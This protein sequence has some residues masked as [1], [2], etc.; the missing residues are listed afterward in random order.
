MLH[1]GCSPRA[2]TPSTKVL[3]RKSSLLFFLPLAITTLL[4][5]QS[6]PAATSALTVVD[7]F[8]P[9]GTTVHRLDAVI[10]FFSEPV[11]GVDASDFLVNGVAATNLVI[12]SQSQY[13]FLFAQPATTGTVQISWA[14]DHGIHDLAPVPNTFD[15]TGWSYTL[16]TNVPP[17]VIINE[18]L[19]SNSGKTSVTNSIRDEDGDASDWIELLNVGPLAVDLGGWFL[20]DEIA[21]LTKWR[22]PSVSILP[23]DFLLVWASGKNRT[24]AATPLHTNFQLD[25]GGAYLALVD[26]NRTVVSD[27]FPA[28]P[29]QLTDVSYGRDRTDPTLVGYFVVP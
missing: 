11:E 20:T 14:P 12:G 13:K 19:A 6:A 10:V 29:P 5:P 23:S 9:A 7:Q 26:P 4:A 22:F 28:F 25:K 3:M 2:A 24:N 8:P 1:K 17:S 16:D 18:F 21:N 27:F 15:G